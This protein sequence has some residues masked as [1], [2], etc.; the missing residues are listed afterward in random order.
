VSKTKKYI[1][2]QPGTLNHEVGDVIEL[3]DEKAKMLVNKVA[4]KSENSTQVVN[5]NIANLEKQLKASSATIINHETTI[6]AFEKLLEESADAIA[7]GE[8][9][10]E[11]YIATIT[12]HEAT[13]ADLEKQK[14]DLIETVNE[15]STKA[16][17][18]GK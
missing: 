2:T 3:T 5:Q 15:L 11:E 4:L 9:E 17:K 13:I 8:G 12:Q 16:S 18:P 1:V 10:N 14:N 7:N 6:A